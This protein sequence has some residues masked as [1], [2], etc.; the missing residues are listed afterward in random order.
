[1][2]T[3][4]SCSFT[5]ILP[6]K[7][8]S[9]SGKYAGRSKKHYGVVFF[10]YFFLGGHFGYFFFFSCSGRGRGGVQGAR[11]RGEDRLLLKNPRKRG[12]Q[13]GCLQRIGEFFWGG[14][15]YMFFS[16]LKCPCETVPQR[17]VS[18][19]FCLVFTGYRASIA[20]I[21]LFYRNSAFSTA[22]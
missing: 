16:G 14:G 3:P 19:A 1:M 5:D 17:G 9:R 6:L 8:G 2:R 11:T 4:L 7:E 21:P 12:G 18:H 10:H 20:E 22:G 15:G 13:G